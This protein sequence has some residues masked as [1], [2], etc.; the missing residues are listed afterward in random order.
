MAKLVLARRINETIVIKIGDV[1]VLVTIA[2]IAGKQAKVAICAPESVLIN[3]EEMQDR[4]DRRE[5]S[6]L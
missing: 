1:K 3:R 4:L 5:A 2:D 6:G